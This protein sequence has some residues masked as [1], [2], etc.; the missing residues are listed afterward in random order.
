MCWDISALLFPHSLVCSTLSLCLFS[1]FSSPFYVFSSLSVYFNPLVHLLCLI[2]ISNLYVSLSNF[3]L[4]IQPINKTVVCN[5]CCLAE[6]TQY[7]TRFSGCFSCG[8]VTQGAWINT[9]LG[10]LS[11][12]H[13]L[14]RWL[15]SDTAIFCSDLLDA[16]RL[17]RD[18]VRGA[19]SA[20]VI[21]AGNV[22]ERAKWRLGQYPSVGVTEREKNRQKRLW[23]K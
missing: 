16:G 6:D 7:H 5:L 18:E 12:L 17:S 8:A 20:T 22:L 15:V 1:V 3:K 11:S 14:Y 19:G 10:S 21:F 13:W 9:C 2:P 23:M 4:E